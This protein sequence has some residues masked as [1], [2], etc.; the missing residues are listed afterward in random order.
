MIF[1]CCSKHN[2]Y[3]YQWNCV[4]LHTL[5]QYFI[6]L[7]H[8]IFWFIINL[9]DVG[10][11][12]IGFIKPILMKFYEHNLHFSTSIITILPCI[13]ILI[14]LYAM[15]FTYRCLLIPPTCSEPDMRDCPQI[16]SA[17]KGGGGGCKMRTMALTK[18]N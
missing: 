10:Y 18:Y 12:N 17:A 4:K 16:L 3:V 6:I 14:Y 7:G 2:T 13:L 8:M 11:F 15:A 5:F 1:F 9:C